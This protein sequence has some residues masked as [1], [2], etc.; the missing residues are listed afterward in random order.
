MDEYHYDT[1]GGGVKSNE[2]S[3]SKHPQFFSRSLTM[4]M[5]TQAADG[6]AD[7]DDER[8]GLSEPALGSTPQLQLYLLKKQLRYASSRLLPKLA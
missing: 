1:Y 7:S 4:D 2:P 8:E 6:G 3:T 5:K